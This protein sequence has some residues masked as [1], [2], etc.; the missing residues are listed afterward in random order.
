MIQPCE[1]EDQKPCKF[2]NLADQ[3]IVNLDNIW[4]IVVPNPQ[5][6]DGYEDRARLVIGQYISNAEYDDRF[7]VVICDE[8]YTN[9]YE[10]AKSRIVPSLLSWY[11]SGDF[12]QLPHSERDGDVYVRLSKVSSVEYG[13]RVRHPSEGKTEHHDIVIY[14]SGVREVNMDN[15]LVVTYSDEQTAK[16]VFDPLSEAMNKR[17]R[18]HQGLEE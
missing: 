5:K 14:Y 12:F 1:S 7:P 13:H 15:G 17:W 10:E 16:S 4:F 9:S 8:V 11:G 6:E 3:M 18:R 2:I